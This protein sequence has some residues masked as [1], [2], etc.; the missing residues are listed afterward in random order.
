MGLAFALLIVYPPGHSSGSLVDISSIIIWSIG[1]GEILDICFVCFAI[2]SVVAPTKSNS[3]CV[4]VSRWISVAWRAHTHTQQ[5]TYDTCMHA[6]THAC[7]PTCICLCVG[8][9]RAEKI[10]MVIHVC[11]RVRVHADMYKYVYVNMNIRICTYFFISVADAAGRRCCAGSAFACACASPVLACVPFVG[12]AF[13]ARAHISYLSTP[14]YV[15]ILCIA[16]II[17][18]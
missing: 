3:L 1:G 15:C 9:W 5:Y 13:V 17:L 12:V 8:G 14:Q 7:I 18:N 2:A 6:N 10:H 16:Y 11:L 4:H